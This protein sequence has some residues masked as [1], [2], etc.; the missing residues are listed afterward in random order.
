MQGGLISIF[1]SICELIDLFTCACKR[2]AKDGV[3]SL[4]GRS[5]ERG[6]GQMRIENHPILRFSRGKRLTFYFEGTPVEAFENETIAAALIANGIDAFRLSLRHK[7]P[8]GLFCAIGKCSSCLVEVDGRPN[9]RAC[10]TPVREGMH[11]HLQRDR[12]V[13]NVEERER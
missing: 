2:T 12:G 13:V 1:I 6:G 7:K 10:M 8:R 9:V 4:L 3:E 5:R 11:V